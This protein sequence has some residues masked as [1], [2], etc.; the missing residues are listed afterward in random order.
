MVG[1]EG[2][3]VSELGLQFG[4]EDLV[5]CHGLPERMDSFVRRPL[6][7]GL[8]HGKTEKKKNLVDGIIS[9]K[10]IDS[11]CETEQVTSDEY[12]YAHQFPNTCLSTP[13]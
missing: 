12:V 2:Q 4:P 6:S 7:H 11:P 9:S 3:D 1:H 8:P 13:R 5:L 10:E